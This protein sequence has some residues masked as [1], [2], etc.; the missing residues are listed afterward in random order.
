MR[1]LTNIKKVVFKLL[2]SKNYKPSNSDEKSWFSK[3]RI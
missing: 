1:Q 2:H 3:M